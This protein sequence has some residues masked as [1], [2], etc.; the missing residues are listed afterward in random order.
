MGSQ[1]DGTWILGLPGFRVERI[2]GEKALATSR[3]RVYIER[4][5][6]RYPCGGCGRRTSRVRSATGRTWDDLPWAAH[7]VTLVYQQLSAEQRWRRFPRSRAGTAPLHGR[8]TAVAAEPRADD[9]AVGHE[10][11]PRPARHEARRGPSWSRALRR[12]RDRDGGNGK[13]GTAG[14]GHGD[15]GGTARSVLRW[16]LSGGP[17]SRKQSLTRMREAFENGCVCLLRH[18][19]LRRRKDR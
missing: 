13:A 3:L 2:D 6:R 18:E 10:R 16:Q 11:N 7:P 12:H 8:C 4:R 15:I 14:N 1:R 5:G 19:N 9:R 17:V